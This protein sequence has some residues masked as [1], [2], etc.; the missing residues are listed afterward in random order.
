MR[1]EDAEEIEKMSSKAMTLGISRRVWIELHIKRGMSIPRDLDLEQ[2]DCRSTW[3]Q[4]LPTGRAVSLRSPRFSCVELLSWSAKEADIASWNCPWY[5]PGASV[6]SSIKPLKTVGRM[7]CHGT[8]WTLSTSRP[9]SYIILLLWTASVRRTRPP[10][11]ATI[12]SD[13]VHLKPC[14]RT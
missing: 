7:W 1:R 10:G 13:A 5:G 14:H 3:L 8:R 6:R 12:D 2:M 11:G 9:S 4:S